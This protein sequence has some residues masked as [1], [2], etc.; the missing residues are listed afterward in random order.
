L[1]FKQ[2]TNIISPY[3]RKEL[4]PFFICHIHPCIFMTSVLSLFKD[5]LSPLP[6]NFSNC[7]NYV[8]NVHIDIYKIQYK[9]SLPEIVK[10]LLMTVAHV[11]FLY[12][13][14]GQGY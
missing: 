2:F 7:I 10:L 14:H 9:S 5:S 1:P 12:Q 13:I 8:T 3:Y 11:M 4:F 6:P